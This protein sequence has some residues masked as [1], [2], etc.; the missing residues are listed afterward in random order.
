MLLALV[1]VLAPLCRYTVR[2]I[3]F[4]DL[5]GAEYTLAHSGPKDGALS[6]EGRAMLG[7]L[8][9]DGNVAQ[10]EGVG[11]G[12]RGWWLT[13]EGL[14]PMHLDVAGTDE[15]AARAAWD[16]AVRSPAR[17]RV[18]AEALTSF[19]TVLRVRGSDPEEEARVDQ[20]LTDALAGLETLSATLPR[21]ID[22]PLRTV[23]VTREGEAVLLWA[24]GLDAEPQAALALVYGR[25][26]LAAPP[27]V[28]P[29][30]TLSETLA[31]L[32]LVGDSC[33]CDT[34]R[35]WFGQ[36]RLPLAWTDRQRARAAS[37]LGF[38]PESPMVKS[39]VVRILERGPLEGG[40]PREA[41]IGGADGLLLGYREVEL[42][43]GGAPPPERGFE[44]D[45]GAPTTDGVMVVEGTA[46]DDW[47][48]EDEAPPREP[49]FEAPAEEPGDGGDEAPGLTRLLGGLLLGMVVM[50]MLVVA[51]SG[52]LERRRGA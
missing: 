12:E 16:A 9:R 30:I 40:A 21:A 24:L 5:V 46:G 7:A 23:E 36:P 15:A 34:P 28:G 44:P 48:F 42:E 11:V 38:D 17:D 3:G 14:A 18:L 8:V 52:V 1:A 22:R 39:E 19:A 50:G 43:A 45:G 20:V 26:K 10:A 35:D 49:A 37:E 32:A 13:R 41:A 29:S 6:P 31:Q 25:G 51:T 47:G 4:V 2:D 27:M 33:E